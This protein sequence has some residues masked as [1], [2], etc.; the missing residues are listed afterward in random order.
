MVTELEF[1]EASVLYRYST[2]PCERIGDREWC[3]ETE[4]WQA[5][6]FKESGE[7]EWL[8]PPAPPSSIYL[9]VPSYYSQT[10][11]SSDRASAHPTKG[12]RTQRPSVCMHVSEVVGGARPPRWSQSQ[13]RTVVVVVVADGCSPSMRG[14]GRAWSVGELAG[15]WAGG[16]WRVGGWRVSSFSRRPPTAPLSCRPLFI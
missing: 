13:P 9:V 11:A 14:G 4:W 2:F 1:S 16:G 10:A 3:S 6:V 7:R 5:G 15:K 12:P 8:C